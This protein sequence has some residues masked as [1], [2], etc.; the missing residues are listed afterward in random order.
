M[1]L[2]SGHAIT[3]ALNRFRDGPSN[4]GADLF[5]LRPHRLGLSRDVFVNGFV[6]AFFR[7]FPA[8]VRDG[9]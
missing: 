6:N 4:R 7:E 3:D 2:I 5:E 1:Q 9:K 8:S